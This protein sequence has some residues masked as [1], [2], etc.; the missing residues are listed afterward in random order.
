MNDI[1]AFENQIILEITAIL[2]SAT[3]D[4]YAGLILDHISQE[5]GNTFL[6][7]VIGDVV[8]TSGLR[9]DGIYNEDDIR[10]AIGRV[11]LERLGIER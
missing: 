7:D 4:E 1:Y 2:R 11:F 6:G 5:T 9:D 8:E 3:S 10:L